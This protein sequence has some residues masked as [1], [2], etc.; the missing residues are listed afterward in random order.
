MSRATTSIGGLETAILT[1]A[2][3]F[4]AGVF[5]V[6]RLLVADS[7]RAAIVALVVTSLLVIAWT[8]E[9]ARRATRVEG[10]NLPR[11]LVRRGGMA[12]RTWL[13]VL[14]LVEAGLAGAVLTSYAA[15]AAAVVLPGSPRLEIVA[16]IAAAAYTAAH[17]RIEGL[18]RTVY[19]AFMFAALPALLAFTLL[20]ARGEQIA[21]VW[22]GPHL[23]VLPILNGAFDGLLLYSGT[24]AIVAFLPVHKSK[25]VPGV[26]S[27]TLLAFALIVIAFVATLATAGPNFVLTQVWPVVSALRTLVLA[28]FVL[29]RFGLIV[30]LAWSAFALTFVAVHLWVATEYTCLAVG[31][32]TWRGPVALVAS[33]LAVF[34]S[35]RFA[36]VAAFESFARGVVV[37]MVLAVLV[38]W[39]ALALVLTWRRPQ[40]AES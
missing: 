30:V 27:G 23:A 1:A 25:G 38:I 35:T 29:N 9:M 34:M 39:L 2:A 28:S 14:A 11:A 4:A 18:A 10:R 33:A 20:L 7:G 21:T 8:W 26:V 36:S 19:V 22:P 5:E 37:P 15:M 24:A 17:H 31:S 13:I 40:K 16:L 12:G 3:V 6:P 32:D